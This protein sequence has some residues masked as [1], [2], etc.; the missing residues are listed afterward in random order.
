MGFFGTK[1]N[2]LRRAL[3]VLSQLDSRI[4]Q[5][6]INQGIVLN[7]LHESTQSHNLHDYEYKI[8]S[9]WGEDGII[10]HLVRTI[11]ITNKTFIEFGVEDFSES[12]CRY[13]LM[14]DNWSGMVIDGSTRNIAR[15]KTNDYYWRYDLKALAA[16]ITRENIN[17]LLARGGFGPDLGLLSID[18][19][20]ND[21]WVWEAVTVSPA[22]AIVEY[23]A[24]FGPERQVT[25]P[26]DPHFDRTK[27][28]YSNLYY[29]ASLAAL[30]ALGKRKG[31][32]FVGSNSAGNNAF[33]V[34]RDLRPS[35][36]LELTPE[37]GFSP[38]KAR[39]SRRK[40]RS[41]SFLTQEQ[42]GLILAGLP[43]VEL[44]GRTSD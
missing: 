25:I 42:E 37:E 28:H 1:I 35:T 6:K 21:Y 5:V 19:D 40:D 31:Y 16:F 39:E 26:Y 14:K 10:Q 7:K 4:D 3:S 34:R 38:V 2:R 23:N 32:C 17:D 33:F 41:L 44:A 13:L 11:G 22:L 36:I 8:F 30:C 29:G 9:Q 20:G 27:A 43:L 12:N 18:I 15:L 24:R